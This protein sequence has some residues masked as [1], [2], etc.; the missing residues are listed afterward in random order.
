MAIGKFIDVEVKSSID[1]YF[2]KEIGKE[3][4]DQEKKIQDNVPLSTKINKTLRNENCSISN[5][6][7]SS[8]C[9]SL[10]LN[11]QKLSLNC[12]LSNKQKSENSTDDINGVETKQNSKYEIQTNKQNKQDI[13][14]FFNK[15]LEI[16]SPSKIIQNDNLEIVSPSKQQNCYSSVSKQIFQPHT[17]ADSNA[18]DLCSN[19]EEVPSVL[20]CEKCN[21]MIDINMYEEHMDHHV[22]VE[23][24]KSLNSSDLTTSKHFKMHKK[25]KT[26]VNIGGKKR[27]NNS[28]ESGPSPKKPYRRI[29]TYFKPIM[30]P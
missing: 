24:S 27:K 30:N 14:S 12:N 17:T 16:I 21:K 19:A 9:P 26:L 28:T 29:S 25:T 6:Q 22:A 8:K 7:S 23:L 18:N 15:K 11:Q 20:L 5:K 13:D 1:K 4:N 10:S 2:N 3:E